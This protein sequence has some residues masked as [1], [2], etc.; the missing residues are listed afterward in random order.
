M[1]KTKPVT[2][3]DIIKIIDDVGV[4]FELEKFPKKQV[5]IFLYRLA[6][7]CSQWEKI[8]SKEDLQKAQKSFRNSL[9]ID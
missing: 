5:D 9:K 4:N 1:G 7:I 8:V 2:T 3:D 6:D